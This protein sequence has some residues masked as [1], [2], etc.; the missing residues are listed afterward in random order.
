MTMG[1]MGGR[2]RVS[3]VGCREVWSFPNGVGRVYS[4]LVGS[5]ISQHDSFAE[6]ARRESHAALFE[7]GHETGAD[8]RGDEVADC[9]APLVDAFLVVFENVLHHDRV[10]LHA[11]DLGD[12]RYL[13]PATLHAVGLND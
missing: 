1:F 2:C 10:L 4:L 7:A 13:A 6:G 12:V 8:A 11:D 9:P 3:G 5:L